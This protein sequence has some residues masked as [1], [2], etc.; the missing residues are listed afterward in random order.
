M[1]CCLPVLLS[2]SWGKMGV[3][4]KLTFHT[5]NLDTLS[6]CGIPAIYIPSILLIS[7]SW[8]D[9]T[10]Q[11]H[12][13]KYICAFFKNLVTIP[14]RRC[15]RRHHLTH[16][17]SGDRSENIWPSLHLMTLSP[18]RLDELVSQWWNPEQGLVFNSL[19]K[20]T[21]GRM[22]SKKKIQLSF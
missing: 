21:T 16:K 12:K 3:H 17:Q 15:T 7:G 11:R 1:P 18:D 8:Q 5:S 9:D 6:N 10:E 2:D 4:M 14:P 19:K 22:I 13:P 20:I